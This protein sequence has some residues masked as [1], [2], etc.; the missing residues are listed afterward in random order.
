MA[1]KIVKFKNLY[2]TDYEDHCA[3][4]IAFWFGVRG[5]FIIAVIM[6]LLEFFQMAAHIRKGRS[7]FCRNAD[8]TRIRD[9]TVFVHCGVD[10]IGIARNYP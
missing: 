5:F 9:C 3:E 7:F 6:I 2:S 4:R 8:S 1:P 10:R